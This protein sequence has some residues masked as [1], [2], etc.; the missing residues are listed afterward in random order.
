MYLKYEFNCFFQVGDRK[1]KANF[2]F[3]EKKKSILIKQEK[4]ILFSKKM[5]FSIFHIFF[6]AL[7]VGVNSHWSYKGK[8]GSFY[9]FLIFISNLNFYPRIKC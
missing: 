9:I 8:E 2:K 6:S 3:S 5:Y 1:E 7:L 4:K